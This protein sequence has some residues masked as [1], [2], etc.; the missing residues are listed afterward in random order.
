VPRDAVARLHE[1][2]GETVPAS[3][4][5]TAPADALDPVAAWISTALDCRAAEA[6][7]L[8]PDVDPVHAW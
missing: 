4:W 6:F 5:S 1:S 2:L 7:S 8:D 3:T